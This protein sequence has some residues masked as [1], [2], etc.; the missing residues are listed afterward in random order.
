V[1]DVQT[2]KSLTTQQMKN[3]VNFRRENEN[4][5]E[6][7]SKLLA[8]FVSIDGNYATVISDQGGMTTGIVMQTKAQKELFNYWGENLVLDWTHNTNN[9]GFYLGKS[10]KSCS[11]LFMK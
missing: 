8:A 2:G 9:I 4:P 1:C 5:E 10:L 6:E 3:I 11:M 7:L